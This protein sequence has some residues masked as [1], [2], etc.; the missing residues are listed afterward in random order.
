M[1][2]STIRIRIYVEK[3]GTRTCIIIVN[4]IYRY[5]HI[6]EI[7]V[8]IHKCKCLLKT[9]C[10]VYCMYDNIDVGFILLTA[11]CPNN[12][13]NSCKCKYNTNPVNQVS[14]KCLPKYSKWIST[15]SVQ[16]TQICRQIVSQVYPIFVRNDFFFKHLYHIFVPQIY[17]FLVIQ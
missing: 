14:T 9:F 3:V 17:N 1:I 11:W 15:F 4:C 7:N 5:I 12:T 2:L 10:V 16:I 8:L 13:R 6:R